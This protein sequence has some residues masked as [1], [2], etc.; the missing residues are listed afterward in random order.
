MSAQRP[1]YV[2][3]EWLGQMWMS[4]YGRLPAWVDYARGHEQPSRDWHAEDPKFRRVVHWIDRTVLIEPQHLNYPHEPGYLPDCPACEGSCHCNP[5]A[6]A[7]GRE[8]ECVF[9]GRHNTEAS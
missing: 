1:D 5:E 4:V 3:E 9:E 2:P 6:V 8:T 7:A